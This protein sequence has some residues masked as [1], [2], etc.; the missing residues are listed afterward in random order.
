[1]DNYQW[2]YKNSKMTDI[3]IAQQAK[4]QKVIPLAEEKLGIPKDALEPYGHYKAKV[5]L[6]YLDSVEGQLMGS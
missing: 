6:D 4:M 5:D 3:Q 1:M 2:L